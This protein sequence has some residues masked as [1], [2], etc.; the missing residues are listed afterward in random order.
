MNRPFENL[1]T[2]QAVSCLTVGTVFVALWTFAAAGFWPRWISY[3]GCDIVLIAWWLR[4]AMQLWAKLP[5]RN[6][7][8]MFVL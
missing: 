3:A 5:T 7:R 6:A 4:W 2:R 8:G 1:T